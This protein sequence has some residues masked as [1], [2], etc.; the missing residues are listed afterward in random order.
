MGLFIRTHNFISCIFIIATNISLVQSGG[1]WLYEN[2]TPET[3]TASA[4]YAARAQDAA[5]TFGNP[6]GMTRLDSL[7]IL[8]GVPVYFYSLKFSIDSATYGGGNGGNA[9]TV[10]PSYGIYYVNQILPHTIPKLRAG[11]NLNSYIGGKVDYNANWSGRFYTQKLELLTFHNNTVFAYPVTSWLSIG[12]GFDGI[13]G[14]LKQHAAVN[15]LLDPGVGDGRIDI[16]ETNLGIGGDA[17]ILIIPLPTLRIGVTY[18]SPVKLRFRNALAVSGLGPNLFDSLVNS[19]VIGA[20]LTL[21]IRIPQTFTAGIYMDLTDKVA[22]MADVNWQHWKKF[23]A[24]EIHVPSASTSSLTF[25]PQ[26]KNTFHGAIGVHFRP[27]PRLLLTTGFSFDTSPVTRDN[28]TPSFPVDRQ[29]RY[30]GGIGLLVKKWL[31]LGGAYEYAALGKAQIEQRR[32]P[33]SGTLIGDYDRN[34]FNVLTLY[35]KVHL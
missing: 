7:N 22:L 14:K 26:L 11:Y 4:G 1:A 23:N 8:A 29:Y 3:G 5:T 6:A 12:G 21:D 9:G 27:A 24:F 15:N 19:G 20:K 28:R 25:T 17:G 18:R 34:N 10:L 35:V 2:G 16:E 33:L 13:Y 32:G 31:T 30:A